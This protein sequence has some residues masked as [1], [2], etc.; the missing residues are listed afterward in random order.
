MFSSALSYASF[1]VSDTLQIQKET[2]EEYK[3]RMQKQGFQIQ[4]LNLEDYQGRVNKEGLL[5][6]KNTSFKKKSKFSKFWK[7][8][9]IIQKV[10]LIILGLFLIFVALLMVAIANFNPSFDFSDFNLDGL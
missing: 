6:N 4:T 10:L 8:K 1:P 5:N 9:T 2:L 7:A 3:Y